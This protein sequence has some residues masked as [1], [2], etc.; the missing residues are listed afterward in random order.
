MVFGPPQKELP[1]P[2]LGD[3]VVHSFD[4]DMSAGSSD[5]EASMVNESIGSRLEEAIHITERNNGSLLS[6]DKYEA[7]GVGKRNRTGFCSLSTFGACTADDASSILTSATAQETMFVKVP[8]GVAPSIHMQRSWEIVHKDQKEAARNR[9]KA[10]AAA[11]AAAAAKQQESAPEP[12]EAAEGEKESKPKVVIDSSALEADSFVGM[13]LAIEKKKM[14][15]TQPET[16]STV[17]TAE[18]E[19]EPTLLEQEKEEE[20]EAAEVSPSRVTPIQNTEILYV[21]RDTQKTKKGGIFVSF[22]SKRK[23]DKKQIADEEHVEEYRISTSPGSF[24]EAIPVSVYPAD[25]VEEVE[26]S[27]EVVYMHGG[28]CIFHTPY[29]REQVQL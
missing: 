13:K 26:P 14:D 24:E 19:E 5:E 1:P 10:R 11:K 6:L 4:D 28:S 25:D 9:R 22:K 17:A 18:E 7:E 2:A 12:Q 15:S 20:K 16:P 8:P 27:L 29:H 21:P 23:S 3:G